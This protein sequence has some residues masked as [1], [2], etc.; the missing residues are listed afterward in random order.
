M[1]KV[2]IKKK[3][4]LTDPATA[5]ARKVLRIRYRI[6]AGQHVKD[7]CKRHLRDLRQ[8]KKRGIYYDKE[9]A[10]KAFNEA[11]AS[12]FKGANDLAEEV[13]S[14]KFRN[15]IDTF[16]DNANKKVE[17]MAK[18]AT[19]L[20]KATN[21]TDPGTSPLG[22]TGRSQSFRQVDLSRVSIGGVF[23]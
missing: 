6:V 23:I 4:I 12:S 18:Q 17:S 3:N 13:R 2:K 16:M 21:F 11:S 15:A 19:K 5:Y 1:A 9:S 22:T 10:A 8:Q 20:K 14:G 7:A